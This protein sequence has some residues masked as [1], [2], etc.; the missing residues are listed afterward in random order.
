MRYE[1]IAIHGGKSDDSGKNAVNYPIYLS[2]TFTQP[3][4]DQFEE[5]VYS[6][7]NN[8][9]RS[10]VEKLVAELEGAKYGLALASGMAATSLVFGLLK[11]GDKVLI[12][13]NVYGGTW[14]YVSNIFAD[15]GIEY[16]VVDDFNFYDFNDA[17]ANVKMVFIETPSN[18]LLEITDIRKVSEEAKKR[19]ILTVVDNTFL[20]SYFQ[21]PLVLG[22]DIVVYSATKYYAGHSDILA[23]LVVLN[24]EELYTKLKFFQNTYG[25]ILSPLD[26]FLLTRGIKT[27]SLRLEKHQ[28]NALLIAQYFENHPA[29]KDVYYPG[30]KSHKNYELQRF[31]AIGDGGVLS[32][33]LQDGWDS[34]KF[35]ENLKFFGLAVSL[36]GVE[37]LICHPA[38]MTHESY[39]PEWQEKIGIDSKLLRLAVGI[40]HE[41]DLLEDLSNALDKA[42]I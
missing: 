5:F 3:S 23:G 41:E 37:S 17:A 36:G 22:A 19:N 9:T 14:R 7:G 20:T 34:K 35:I 42:K 11:Q 4:L 28:K 13:N 25:G 21:K 18:P 40:E 8:P 10:N 12:N 39:S 26:S 38:S 32:F 16:E 29:V 15:H 2:S 33:R 6:R 30:L 27:L 1:S 31:Q 24:D